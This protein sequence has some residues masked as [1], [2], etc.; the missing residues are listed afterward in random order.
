ME[1]HR[2]EA[3]EEEE[4]AKEEEE[5]MMLSLRR[6]GRFMPAYSKALLG[7]LA[8]DCAGRAAVGWGRRTTGEV[9]MEEARGSQ[10]ASGGGRE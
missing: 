2:E 9:E 8:Q 6:L 4:E 7:R 3:E 1:A 10:A 5:E